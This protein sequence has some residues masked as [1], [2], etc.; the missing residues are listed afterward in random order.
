MEASL[1]C[2]WVIWLNNKLEQSLA[3]GFFMHFLTWSLPRNILLHGLCWPSCKSVLEQD[4]QAA[5]FE[6]RHCQLWN[7]IHSPSVVLVWELHLEMDQPLLSQHMSAGLHSPSNVNNTV[8]PILQC[9]PSLL[10]DTHLC[11]YKLQEAL[12]KC[13]EIFIINK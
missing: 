2:Y 9:S 7:E 10:L 6:M 11:V 12:K 5:G 1:Q 8:V 13:G 3:L 4:P